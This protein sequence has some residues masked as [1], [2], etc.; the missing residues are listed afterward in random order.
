MRK[1]HKLVFTLISL[2]SLPCIAQE[3]K[4]SSFK[5]LP[6]KVTCTDTGNLFTVPVT[7]EGITANF[8]L[9]TGSARTI[10]YDV[11]VGKGLKKKLIPLKGSLSGVGGETTTYKAAIKNASVGSLLQLGNQPEALFMKVDHI[12]HMKIDGKPAHIKGLVGTPLL[13]KVRAVFDYGVPRILIPTEGTPKNTYKRS[14]VSKGAHV[15]PLTAG[16]FDFPYVMV[17]IKGKDYAFLVDTGANSNVIEPS[18]AKELGL[19][20]SEKKTTVSGTNKRGGIR[21]TIVKEP[22]LGGK[23]Q[24]PQMKCYVM[25][26]HGKLQPPKGLKAGGIIGTELLKIFKAQLDFDSYSLII[27]KQ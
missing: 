10:I 22:L 13:K 19:P 16:S 5:F 2:L 9:D 20:L 24:L 23:I 1:S 25:D 12:A 3:T 4:T 7:V 17:K 21:Y 15:V 6:L 27:P 8:L 11:S 18:V 26:T 14:Q